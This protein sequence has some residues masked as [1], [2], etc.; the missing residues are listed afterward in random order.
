MSG[1]LGV[2][3]DTAQGRKV[4]VEE[5]VRNLSLS[6]DVSID[7][8]TSLFADSGKYTNDYVVE[9]DFIRIMGQF[10]FHGSRFA[11]EIVARLEI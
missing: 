11:K 8:L 5:L 2:F 10:D 1:A 3:R 4:T 7:A 6:M 9:K